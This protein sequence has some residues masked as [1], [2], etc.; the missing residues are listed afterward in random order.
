MRGAAC[1]GCREAV[2]AKEI[3]A[4]VPNDRVMHTVFGLGTVLECDPRRTVIEFDDNNVRKFVTSLV[5][6][7][8]AVEEAPVP[9]SKSGGRSKAKKPAAPKAARKKK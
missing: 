5:Q 3:R 2:V 7:E 4:F 9:K 1:G 6:L 8:K